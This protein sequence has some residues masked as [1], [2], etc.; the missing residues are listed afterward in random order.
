MIK[1][2]EPVIPMDMDEPMAKM[3]C[4]HTPFTFDE[5][6][7]CIHI[8]ES[9]DRTMVAIHYAC[10][11][12]L[13]LFVAEIDTRIIKDLIDK[14]ESSPEKKGMIRKIVDTVCKVFKTKES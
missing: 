2:Y 5:I 7:H 11:F 12:A 13:P 1:G 14:A 6:L 9:I 8:T 4:K 3:I 10:T